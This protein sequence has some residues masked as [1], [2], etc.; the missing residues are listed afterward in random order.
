[1]N[2]N[3][4][5][6]LKEVLMETVTQLCCVLNL[7]QRARNRTESRQRRD[8]SAR[9]GKLYNIGTSR[10]ARGSRVKAKPCHR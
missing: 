9:G 5:M 3:F 4:Q 7:T 8:N 2:L 10:Y 1:M 6:R